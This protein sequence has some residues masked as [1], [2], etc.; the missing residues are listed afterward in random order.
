MVEAQKQNLS[1]PESR[2]FWKKKANLLQ[3]LT[4][5]KNVSLTSS[6]GLRNRKS[7]KATT[8]MK[9]GWSMLR[10]T[11]L[12][13]SKAGEPSAEGPRGRQT[14]AAKWGDHLGQEQGPARGYGHPQEL[15]ERTDVH[16]VAGEDH[17]AE[18][19]SKW[20]TNQNPWSYFPDGK[21][22]TWKFWPMSVSLVYRKISCSFL[23]LQLVFK[24]DCF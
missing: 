10:I 12:L 14:Q 2:R 23:T 5:W 11:Q 21:D 15:E 9:N 4:T 8:W 13:K 16:P 3:I 7:L 6:S 24:L 17:W 19:W 22:L 20:W 1:K 18:D